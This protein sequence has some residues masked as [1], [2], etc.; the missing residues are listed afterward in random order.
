MTTYDHIWPEYRYGLDVEWGTWRADDGV[1]L[2]CPEGRLAERMNNLGV[3]FL[4][5]MYLMLLE[6]HYAMG[7]D[8]GIVQ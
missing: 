1:Y 6:C 2:T 8:K 4:N 5:E 7:A 3:S